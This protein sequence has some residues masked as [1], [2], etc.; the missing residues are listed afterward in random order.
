MMSSPKPRTLARLLW[1]GVG[2]ISMLLL[3]VVLRE[4]RAAV[5]TDFRTAISLFFGGLA[6]CGLLF[7][8]GAVLP[9]LVFGMLV[10]KLL[11]D[12][13]SKSHEEAVFKDLGIPLIGACM[14]AMVGWL[15]DYNV[16]HP[17]VIRSNAD[18]G[19]NG[20]SSNVGS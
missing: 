4:N 7:N 8:W 14:G 10:L 9:C 20:D 15:L 1:I 6:T 2:L 11:I 18:E 5:F 17:H 3:T 13:M 12:P 19:G 16:D